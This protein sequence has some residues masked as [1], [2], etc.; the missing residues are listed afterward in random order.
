MDKRPTS[1]TVRLLADGVEVQNKTVTADTDWEFTFEDLPKF[2][3]TTE[4]VYTISEDAVADYSTSISN[5]DIANTHAPEQLVIPVKKVWVDDNDAQSLRPT[6]V[7][8]TLF[9]DGEKS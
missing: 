2:N 6:S 7:H 5:Y 1:I 3:G 9:A 8:V 4:T